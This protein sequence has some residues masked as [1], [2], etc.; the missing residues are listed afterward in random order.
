M[1]RTND[2]H[3]GSNT[4]LNYTAGKVGNLAEYNAPLIT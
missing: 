4:E 3:L 2:I 1:I